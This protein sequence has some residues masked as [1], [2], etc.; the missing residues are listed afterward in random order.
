MVS[1]LACSVHAGH[2]VTRRADTCGSTARRR[3]AGVRA[4]ERPG[5]RCRP[6]WRGCGPAPRGGSRRPARR[7]SPSRRQERQ[8]DAPRED[9]PQRRRGGQE[10]IAEGG[11]PSRSAP[12]HDG[13]PKEGPADAPT[14]AARPALPR[15][16]RP[17]VPVSSAHR[18]ARH[19]HRA[20]RRADRNRRQRDPPRSLPPGAPGRGARGNVVSTAFISARRATKLIVFVTSY[21]PSLFP[22]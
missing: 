14:R 13:R 22:I 4:P 19:A 12:G 7:T 11:F 6:C 18:A 15:V 3:S 1:L 16:L 20:A 2:G 5:R 21:P 8:H 9:R 17:L 10:G